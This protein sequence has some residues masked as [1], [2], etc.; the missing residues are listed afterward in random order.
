MDALLRQAPRGFASAEPPI[1]SVPPSQRVAHTPRVPRVMRKQ[2]GEH[3]TKGLTTVNTITTVL[4][5]LATA[6]I[7]YLVLEALDERFI[8]L[9]GRIVQ[10]EVTER[11]HREQGHYDG[12]PDA[13]EVN[14]DG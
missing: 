4:K 13:E 11:Y 5:H 1:P 2:P 10:L 14:T 7:V 8:Q 6:L 12:F 9:E 3:L